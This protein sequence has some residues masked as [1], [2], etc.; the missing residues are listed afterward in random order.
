MQA[1]IDT[2]QQALQA[3]PST[4]LF[5]RYIGFLT[6]QL[7]QHLQ[8]G[9]ADDIDGATAAQHPANEPG[10][11]AA[12]AQVLAAFEQAADAGDRCRLRF[13]CPDLA[14]WSVIACTATSK[15][16]SMGVD[17]LHS[18]LYCGSDLTHSS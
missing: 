1:A 4:E 12:A 17:G 3:A 7:Q 2:Y 14:A 15:V 9:D 16:A 18:I 8:P 5:D 6:E 10:A 11:A 13:R